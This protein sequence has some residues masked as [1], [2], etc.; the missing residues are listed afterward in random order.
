[1][2][3]SNLMTDHPSRSATPPTKPKLSIREAATKLNQSLSTVY[4]IDRRSGPFRFILEGRRIFVDAESF[5]M[6]LK[7]STMSCD[8]QSTE[9]FT[10]APEDPVTSADQVVTAQH[11]TVTSS[12]NDSVESCGQR[13]LII[14]PKSAAVFIYYS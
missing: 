10:V 7:R 8:R 14:R 6:Y 2:D 1:M 9:Q 12:A 5:D 13:D 3:K 4:R 11:H